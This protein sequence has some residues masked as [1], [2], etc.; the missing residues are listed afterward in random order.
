L[1][2]YYKVRCT[3][4][5]TGP[6]Y[7]APQTIQEADLSVSEIASLRQTISESEL[8]EETQIER[9]RKEG[10]TFRRPLQ[11]QL[12]ELERGVQ[13]FAEGHRDDLTQ[14]G[15]TKSVK[16]T[17]GELQWR[18]TPPE[19]VVSSK[20]KVATI[21][22]TLKRRGLARFVRVKE[23]LD[24]QALKK[25][26]DVIGTVRGLRLDQHEEFIIKT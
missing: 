13:A 17:S 18:M 22:A 25:E 20:V 11:E 4:R 14:G 12:A 10:A 21:I 15:R 7:Y 5:S 23:E 26:P 16:L 6:T 1:Q 8:G 9:I 24:K 3:L 19:L 2:T